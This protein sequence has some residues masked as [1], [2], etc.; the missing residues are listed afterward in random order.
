MAI[1][2]AVFVGVNTARR[3]GEHG[4][5]RADSA[6]GKGPLRTNTGTGFT[7][8]ELLVVVALVGIVATI[9]VPGLLRA[10]MTGTEAFSIGSLRAIGSAQSTHAASWCK[11]VLCVEPR[12]ARG[13][14]DRGER[15]RRWRDRPKYRPGDNPQLHY[16]VS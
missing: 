9:A 15:C 16:T 3:R 12:H 10:Q 7:L 11:R 1:A 5:L 2:R 13:R 8:I 4:F 14:R 6:T